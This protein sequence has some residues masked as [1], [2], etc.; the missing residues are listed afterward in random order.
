LRLS[1]SNE[2]NPAEKPY[3]QL[4]QTQD[5]VSA[6]ASS[7]STAAG[8]GFCVKKRMT[9]DLDGG[10]NHCGHELVSVR[11]GIGAL[12]FIEARE[13][14]PISEL[15]CSMSKYELRFHPKVDRQGVTRVRCVQSEFTVLH[16]K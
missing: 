2:R 6:D 1:S 12:A 9:H 10:I 5:V 15:A 14:R 4:P 11:P 7:S 3:S 8:R 13:A 16:K